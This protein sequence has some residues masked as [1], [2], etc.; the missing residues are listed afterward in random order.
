MT[1]AGFQIVAGVDIW[2]RATETFQKNHPSARVFTADLT[3]LSPETVHSVIGPVNVI[4]GGP[5]CQGFSMAGRR[6]PKDP[7][8]SLF[9]EFVKYIDFFRPRMF[10]MENVLGIL[11][12]RTAS[13]ERVVDI[14]LECL[15]KH[16]H[17]Q[18]F[19]LNSADFGV[20]Q[21][22][23]R[24]I[25]FGIL[26]SEAG[27]P[28]EIP[29]PVPQTAPLPVKSVLLSRETVLQREPKAFLSERAI[30]GILR[31]R[32]EMAQKKFGF[33]AQ[34]LDLDRPSFTISARY[35]KDGYDALVKYSESEIRRLTV[36]E[37]M[38]IQTF[39]PD[40]EFCGTR[41][42]IIQQIGNAV[43]CELAF[44]IGEFCWKILK[45]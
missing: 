37:L 5:P 10:V 36:P 4:V 3:E 6:D 2:N 17:V 45:K 33:G 9:M 8:N 26:Q 29:T 31:R 20:P 12:M 39:P 11:S 34:I 24:V 22:R 13:G 27:N 15:T 14:L 40:F 18:Y 30:A 41:K 44:H 28:P 23:K 19:V 16:F 42:E 35:Y 38:A 43:P 32:Q 21:N 1:K 7:R 25:F